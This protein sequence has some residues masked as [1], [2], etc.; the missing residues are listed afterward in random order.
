MV[1]P[2]DLNSKS[3]RESNRSLF[4]G[5]LDWENCFPL[6]IF[7]ENKEQSLTLVV[8]LDYSLFAK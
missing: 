1:V 2:G 6:S 5:Y 3:S 8:T 7:V 4:M